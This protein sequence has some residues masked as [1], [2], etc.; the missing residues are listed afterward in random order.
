MKIVKVQVDFNYFLIIFMRSL[1]FLG[2]TPFRL[3]AEGVVKLVFIGAPA[4]VFPTAGA[5]RL[6]FGAEES[7]QSKS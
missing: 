4:V 6:A 2:V 5:Q 1:W 7:N 3:S